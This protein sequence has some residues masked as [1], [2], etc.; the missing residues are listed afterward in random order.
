VRR[1]LFVAGLALWSILGFASEA[2]RTRS[3]ALQFNCI[4]PASRWIG[5]TPVENLSP[6]KGGADAVSLREYF[7]LDPIVLLDEFLRDR[8][9]SRI[10]RNAFVRIVVPQVN[11]GKT[12]QEAFV[13]PP[14]RRFL[15]GRLLAP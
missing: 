7:N 1:T 9:A 3:G 15:A 13:R 12:Y 4:D 11:A 5:L 14:I 6:V 2:A 10:N 8:L